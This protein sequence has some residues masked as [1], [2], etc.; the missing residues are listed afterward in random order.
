MIK[1]ALIE[2]TGLMC[3]ELT[4]SESEVG[5]RYDEVGLRAHAVVT[6]G[7]ISALIIII[8]TTIPHIVTFSKRR[9]AAPHLLQGTF[10]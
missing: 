5:D 1:I 10:R 9:H 4:D 2:N 7:H 6:S 3:A 8:I